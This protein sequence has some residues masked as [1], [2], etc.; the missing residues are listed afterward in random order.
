MSSSSLTNYLTQRNVDKLKG[1]LRGKAAEEDIKEA[2]Q[3][4]DRLTQDVPRN[5]ASQGLGVVSGEQTH[6][7][8][9]QRLLNTPPWATRRHQ[10]VLSATAT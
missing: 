4:L 3:R 7:T 1:F 8:L 6:S 10:Y 2:L 5:V 9:I